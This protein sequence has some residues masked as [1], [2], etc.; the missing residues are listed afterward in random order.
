M[1][2]LYKYVGQFCTFLTFLETN[3]FLDFKDINLKQNKK[4]KEEDGELEEEVDLEFLQDFAVKFRIHALAWSPDSSLNVLPKCISFCSASSDFTLRMYSSNTVD[5]YTELVLEGHKSYINSVAYESSGD[6]LASV[7]D[8]LTC[9]LWSVKENKEC[10]A[11]FILKSP[12]MSVC[13]HNEEPGK[14]LVGE[15]NGTVRMY[16][17][18]KQQAILSFETSEVPLL[19]ADWSPANSLLVAALAGG[20]LVIWNTTRPN[21]PIEKRPLHTKGCLLRFAQQ[22][23]HHVAMIG[24][25]GNTLKVV[26]TCVKQPVVN[27]ALKCVGGLSWHHRLPYVCAGVDH[28]ICLWKVAT[29]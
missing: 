9:K 13:W 3:N 5:P 28:S 4:I 25:P 8:D 16:N 10:F 22:S 26:H 19:S 27:A 7:S 11:T 14:L 29:N 23:E 12:G 17:V 24:Q 15:N 20:N 21:F 2:F 6:Y 1:V 18:E